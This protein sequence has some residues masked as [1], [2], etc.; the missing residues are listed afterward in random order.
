MAEALTLAAIAVLAAVAVGLVRVLR[1]PSRLDRMMAV[2]LL[3]SGGVAVLALLAVASATEAILDV[4]LT[5]ALLAAFA[6]VALARALGQAR[7]DGEEA[8]R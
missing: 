1:G 4:A 2:Q 3:G 5:L 8:G 7:A 6:S